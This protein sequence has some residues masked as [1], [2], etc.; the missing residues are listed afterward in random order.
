[1]PGP[2]YLICIECESPTYDF[3]WERD[4][5]VEILCE[6]CGNE[7]PDQFLTQE[8]FDGLYEQ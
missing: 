3:T 2:E 7:T 4:K 6:V 5:L 1:M 8:D